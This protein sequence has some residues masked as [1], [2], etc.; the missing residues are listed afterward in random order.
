MNIIG[1]KAKHLE[2]FTPPDMEARPTMGRSRE[3][4][5]NSLGDLSGAYVLDLFSGSGAL[6]LEAASRGADLSVMVENAA[7]RCRCI[8][9]N[10]EKLK[11]CGVECEMLLCRSDAATGGS[12]GRSGFDLIFADPPYT[13]SLGYFKKLLSS[14][15]FISRNPG[16]L[17]VWELPDAR[18]TLGPFLEAAQK[19]GCFAAELSVRKFGAASF[20]IGELVCGGQAEQNS[21]SGQQ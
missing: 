8:E 17:L 19:A 10:I 4:L 6:G 3:A 11:R 12:H 13:D 2:L 16:A 21:E 20:L 1:G 14:D 9:K 18:G 5:F 15:F 7:A